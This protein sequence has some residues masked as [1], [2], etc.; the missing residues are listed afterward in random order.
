MREEIV[1]VNFWKE[2]KKEKRE[3]KPSELQGREHL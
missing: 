2:R 3:R 1:R